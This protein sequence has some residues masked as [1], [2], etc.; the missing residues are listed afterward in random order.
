[1]GYSRANCG[2]ICLEIR[3]AITK[4]DHGAGIWRSNYQY[5][6]AILGVTIA[7]DHEI[8]GE[9]NF[10]LY[11]VTYGNWNCN[12]YKRAVVILKE[13]PR[14]YCIAT[15]K[16]NEVSKVVMVTFLIFSNKM[17]NHCGLK[18]AIHYG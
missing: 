13:K 2:R 11:L 5:V 6:T 4:S 9:R 7:R 15:Y 10:A 12:F 1:M 3:G 17:M 18:K 16:M 8:K 14:W